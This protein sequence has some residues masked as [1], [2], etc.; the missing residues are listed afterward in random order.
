M[1][2]VYEVPTVEIVKLASNDI[3][4]ASGGGGGGGKDIITKEDNF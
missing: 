2:L 1:K 3:L 4:N